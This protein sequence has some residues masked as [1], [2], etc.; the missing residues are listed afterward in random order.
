MPELPE[1]ETI[2]RGLSSAL[3]GRVLA[4]ARIGA[5]DLYRS[6]SA[7]VDTLSGG[8]IGRVARVGKAIRIDVEWTGR[9]TTLIAH[10][11]MTGRFLFS[12]DGGDR[13]GRPRRHKHRHGRFVF[14]DG[15][16]LWYVDPRRFGFFYVGNATGIRE[17]LNIGPDPFEIR[18]RQLMARLAGRRAPIKS[19]LL[20]QRLISGLGN[21]YV[22]ELL[23][24][25]GVHPLTR[26]GALCDD[27]ATLLSVT[28]RILRRAIR[29]RG[30][31][32]RDYRGPDGE[33]G[34][35]I[36]RLAVYGREGERCRRCGDGVVRIVVAGRGTHYCPT[37]QRRRRGGASKR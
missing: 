33:P 11:G 4:K 36:Q 26:G 34:E 35:F 13:D 14:K 10:L 30:T 16:E 27:A 2:A 8:R 24:A 9:S 20:D 28:R 17:R 3:T 29:Y 15:T 5:R 1:V 37:C 22:D 18:P 31:M 6:G 23:F 21:I 19:L 32:L 25:A 12:Q 7:R